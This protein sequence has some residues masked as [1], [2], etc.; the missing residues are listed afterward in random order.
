[1]D[2]RQLRYF[3]QIV[4]HGSM[5]SAARSLGVAQPSLSQLVRS[6]ETTLGTEL[7]VRSARGI[8]PTEAGERLESYAVRIERL[9]DDARTDVANIGSSPAGRVAFG[10]PPSICMAL[11]IPM[12]ETLR[13]EQP[14]IQFCVTEAM[15]GHLREWVMN[16]EI[17]MAILYDNTGLGDCTSAFL[18]TEELWFYSAADDWPFD[19][20]PGE[21]VDLKDVI[22]TFLVLPSKRHGLRKFIDRVAQAESRKPLVTLEMDSLPQI[23]SLVARGS[24]YTIIS[25]AAVIDLVEDGKLLGSPI[26]G[27]RLSRKIYLVRSAVNRITAACRAT[28]ECCR[29]VVDDLVTRGIWQANLA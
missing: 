14:E 12:A 10:M 16:G 17:D 2:S 15:S 20:P 29:E 13:L 4:A 23:K 27:P 7:L 9:L 5:S 19:T 25:P 28:E 18:L 6:L 1:M 11:S 8:S 22:T 21:P 26:R 24:G 3:R